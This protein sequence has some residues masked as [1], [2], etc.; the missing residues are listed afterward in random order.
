MK[1]EKKNEDLLKESEKEEETDVVSSFSSG[2]PKEAGETDATDEGKADTDAE[3]RKAYRK[4][5]RRIFTDTAALLA[6][7][8][9]LAAALSLSQKESPPEEPETEVFE[10]EA[11]ETEPETEAETEVPIRYETK[12]S[13][14]WKDTI[15]GGKGASV[16]SNISVTGMSA[17][18]KEETGFRETDFLTAFSVFLND[19][20]I[21]GVTSVNFTDKISCSAKG[22]HAYRAALD[23]E[24]GRVLTVIFYEDYPEYYLF[25]L[26]DEEEPSEIQT[27]EE[28]AE[29]LPAEEPAAEESETSARAYDAS[30]LSISGI[31]KTLLNYMVNRY[32]L[33]Y[34]LYDFLYRNGRV[35]D[36]ASVSDYE[37]DAEKR[38]ALITLTLLDGSS[39]TCT[40]SRDANTYSYR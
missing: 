6:L 19:S 30:S 33:Q 5:W 13:E 3:K 7:L 16:L 4:A 10:T 22:A 21:S 28:S 8:L 27:Q 14:D 39:V 29:T 34:T 9:L 12:E 17:R 36:E 32:E 11:F 24:D 26:A 20:G 25:T 15:F 1:D 23:G 40:Y 2:E 18:E 35:S 37:I 38:E 31:P